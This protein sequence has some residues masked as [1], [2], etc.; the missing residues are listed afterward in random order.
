MATKHPLSGFSTRE[1]SQREPIPGSGQVPNLGG[2]F[3]WAIDDWARLRRFLVLG[4]DGGTYYASERRL[5]R[6]N[7]EAVLRCLALDGVR[8]VDEI[9]EVSTS[10]RN[11]KPAPVV[12]A[13][14][15]C[16]AADDPDVRAHAL[17]ALPKVCRTGTQLFLFR[18]TC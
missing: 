1:T 2:G 5:V 11:P 6:E 3:A 14:A 18:S 10:G 8:T 16:C 4:V 7:G 15:A 9:V 17:A 13:L 12:F